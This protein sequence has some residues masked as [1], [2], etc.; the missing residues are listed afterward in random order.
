MCGEHG[1]EAGDMLHCSTFLKAYIDKCVTEKVEP[2][3]KHRNAYR[4]T[5]AKLQQKS[6]NLNTANLANLEA[7]VNNKVAT[8]LF[9][10]KSLYGSTDTNQTQI[11]ENLFSDSFNYEYDKVKRDFNKQTTNK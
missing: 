5:L 11:Q 6:S 7:R 10:T 8:G 3:E 1:H 2:S 4:D 9:L